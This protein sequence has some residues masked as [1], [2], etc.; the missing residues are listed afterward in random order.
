MREIVEA[1]AAKLEAFS[2][3]SGCVYGVLEAT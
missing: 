1:M 3:E 2:F